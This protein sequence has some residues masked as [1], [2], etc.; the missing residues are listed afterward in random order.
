MKWKGRKRKILQKFVGEI[1][2]INPQAVADIILDEAYKNS[3]S[4]PADDMTVIVAKF[5]KKA[6]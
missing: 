5:W 4:K 3:G 1:K 2:S 6:I